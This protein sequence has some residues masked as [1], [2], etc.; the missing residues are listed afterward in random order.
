MQELQNQSDLVPFGK[1]I[2]QIL[3]SDNSNDELNR[4]T[5]GDLGFPT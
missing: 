1:N 3:H 2:E 5:I 4:I